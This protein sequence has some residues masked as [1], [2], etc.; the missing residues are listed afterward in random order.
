MSISRHGAMLA[1]AV[2]LVAFT[3]SAAAQDD[4][5]EKLEETYGDSLEI[6]EIEGGEVEFCGGGE[7]S[8]VDLAYFDMESGYLDS[9]RDTLAQV[10]RDGSL[11]RYERIRAHALLGEVQIRRGKFR[12]AAHNFR[13]ALELGPESAG[14]SARLGLAVA[15]LRGG[16]REEAGVEAREVV[17]DT[18]EAAAGSGLEMTCFGAL[19]IVAHTTADATEMFESMRQAETVRSTVPDADEPVRE[20]MAMIAPSSG[21]I[22][23]ASAE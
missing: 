11:D 10:I 4:A 21:P 16:Q 15:L 23:V 14:D 19:Q 13:R 18:C 1:I 12:S 6:P 7:A 9:A 17:D 2:S 8:P 22:V 20:V 5:E 3:S